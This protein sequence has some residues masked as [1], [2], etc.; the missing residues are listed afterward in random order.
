MI[1]VSFKSLRAIGCERK[2]YLKIDTAKCNF[3]NEE[4]LENFPPPA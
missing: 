3:A 2:T 1:Q 4:S